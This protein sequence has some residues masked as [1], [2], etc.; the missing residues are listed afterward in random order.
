[1]NNKK[2][3]SNLIRSVALSLVRGPHRR[4]R[5]GGPVGELRAGSSCYCKGVYFSDTERM[6]T[7]RTTLADRNRVGLKRRGNDACLRRGVVVNVL[8]DRISDG[9]ATVTTGEELAQG[10]PF[11]G[12]KAKAKAAASRLYYARRVRYV[13]GRAGQYPHKITRN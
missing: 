8:R 6:Y 12:R 13:T 9:T 4:R 1:M 2:G 3:N 11:T 5:A 7:S 10:I